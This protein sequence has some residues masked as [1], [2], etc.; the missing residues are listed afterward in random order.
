MALWR[1]KPVRWTDRHCGAGEEEVTGRGC[2]D[3]WEHGRR[4]GTG[5]KARDC[6]DSEAG[7]V[8]SCVM[9]RHAVTGADGG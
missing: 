9:R 4:A 8:R 1:K 2:G 5:V 6:G 3:T 7:G